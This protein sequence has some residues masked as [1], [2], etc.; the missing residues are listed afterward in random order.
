MTTTSSNVAFM[1]AYIAG[2]EVLWRMSKAS[3]V[4][5]YGKYAIVMVLLVALFRIRIR[6]NRAFALGYFLMLLPSAVVTFTALDFDKARQEVSFNLSGPLALAV[7]VLFFSN[8]RLT[9]GDLRRTFFAVIA[10]AVGIAAL[11]FFSTT[12]ADDLRFANEGNLI[13]SGGFGP[14]Q[15]SA[16][17]GLAVMLSLLLIVERG[18]AWIA[19]IPLMLIATALAAQS[20]LTFSRGGLVLA[21][22]GMFAAIFYLVRNSGRARITLLVIGTLL[23]GVGKFVIEPRLE[24]FTEGKIGER[25]ASASSTGRDVFIE[26]DLHIFR[27]NPILGVG[28]GMATALRQD[29]GLFGAAHTEYTRLLAEHGIFGAIALAFLFALGVRTLLAATNNT[30]RAYVAAM[31]V[32]AALFLAI[33]AMRLALPSFLFGLACSVAYSSRP[34]TLKSHANWS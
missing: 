16:I 27:D 6:R 1:V 24:E 19:R 31:I 30:A 25:Y 14:N 11:S 2:A 15:V 23:F 28:P 13:A 17:L 10:P 12:S 5:E 18:Q 34:Q 20:A 7:C 33:N 3:V 22:A 4:W 29:L 21:A 9:A 26:Y 32:W 8:V